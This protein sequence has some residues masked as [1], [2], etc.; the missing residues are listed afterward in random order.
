MLGNKEARAIMPL[1]VRLTKEFCEKLDYGHRWRNAKWLV[2]NIYMEPF[3]RVRVVVHCTLEDK[4]DPDKTISY[5]TW[6]WSHEL[7]EW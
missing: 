3:N 4:N 6:Y 1:F 2:T 7:E 5:D